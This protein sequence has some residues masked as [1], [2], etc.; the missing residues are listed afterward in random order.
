MR[1]VKIIDK[2]KKFM[3]KNGKERDS[4]SFYAE[5]DNGYRVMIRPVF[6][7]DYSKLSVLADEIEVK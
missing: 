7:N 6:S 2:N 1:L 3:D 4:V 5:A